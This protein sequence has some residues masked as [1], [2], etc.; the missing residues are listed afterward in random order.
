MRSLFWRI[1]ASFWLAIAL[2]AG[3][4]ILLGHMLNQDAWIL[5]RHPVLNELPKKWVQIYEEQGAA[6]AQDYLQNVKRRNRID[7]QVL[8][9]NGEPVVLGTFPPRAA[10]FEAR[11]QDDSRQLPWR[12]LTTEYT[13]D[14]TGITYLLIFR[15]PH[16]EIED[17][18]RQSLMWP[19]SALGIALVVL[20]LFSLFVTLSIT[21]PLSRLRGAVH[22]LGQTSY[23]QHSLAQLANRRDEFGVLATDFNRMGARLQ[24][25]IGS[26]RQLLRDVSHELRSPLARLRIALALAER[27]E[28]A[29]R[30]K[31]WPRLGRE[32]D[33]LEALISEILALARLDAD[34]GSPEPVELG[35]MLQRLKN[36]TQLDDEPQNIRVQ[37]QDNLQLQGWPDMLERAVDNLLRN[38]LRFSPPGQPIDVQAVRVGNHV[39]LSVR[40]RGPGVAAEHLSQLGE[41]FY[42]APGQT[43][44]GHGLGLAIAKRAAERHGGSLTLGNHPEGGFLATLE[45]PLEPVNPQTN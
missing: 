3:L 19:L 4:S 13:S 32:C 41:P 12:R 16:P 35:S 39:Q 11:Q 28:P 29:E 43:A 21:R 20:T 30:E 17:W 8:N 36:D 6:T 1:L 27:A 34:F 22:D 5:S 18:H 9:D 37:V 23:Q 38:A 10:A 26:Q 31:L 33:R 45:I 42:R 2:V 14:S 40:D 7:V 25:L 24:S 44:P 15:I